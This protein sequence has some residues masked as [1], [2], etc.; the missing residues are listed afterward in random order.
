M[1]DLMQAWSSQSPYQHDREVLTAREAAV[2]YDCFNINPLLLQNEF[3]LDLRFNM[4]CSTLERLIIIFC[5]WHTEMQP[6]L[7]K[8]AKLR[9]D[10]VYFSLL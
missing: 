10:V 5:L 9:I 1:L 3:A 7:Y 4:H 6:L 2:C 8:Y